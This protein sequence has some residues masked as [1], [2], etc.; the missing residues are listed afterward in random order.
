[1]YL[2]MFFR[3]DPLIV[4]CASISKRFRDLILSAL[5][6]E[7]T[8][9]TKSITR[10]PRAIGTSAKSPNPARARAT[11]N[12]VRRLTVTPTWINEACL[13]KRF[14]RHGEPLNAKVLESGG[15]PRASTA[16]SSPGNVRNMAHRMEGRVPF[17]LGLVGS[18]AVGGCSD[19]S[20][21][22]KLGESREK[23]QV[24]VP[25]TEPNPTVAQATPIVGRNV[26]F[27]GHLFPLS[28]VNVSSFTA[29]AG[30]RVYVAPQ[31]ASS[32]NINHDTL[33]TVLGSDGT[34][35]IEQDDTN[36]FFGS[37]SSIAGALLPAAGTYFVRVA[38]GVNSGQVLPY[39]LHFQLRSGVPLAEVEPNDQIPQSF[40]AG[41]ESGWVSGS[42]TSGTDV[43]LYAISL[44]AGDTLFAS[45]D[46]DPER[47][48]VEWDGSLAFGPLANALQL[49]TDAGDTGP[50]SE[51]M[52]LTVKTA[53]RY[54]VRVAAPNT[55]G[56]FGTYTLSVS[57]HPAE[58]VCTTVMSSTPVTLADAA[59]TTATVNFPADVRIADLDVHLDIAHPNPQ[60]LDVHLIA[61]GG[62]D[63]GLFTD[64][65]TTASPTMNVSLDDEAGFPVGLL[66]IISGMVSQPEQ[67]YRLEWF[68]G[69]RAQGTWT[70][71]IEDDLTTNT[72]TLNAWGLSICSV[73]PPPSCP[74]GT[75]QRVV[76][77]TDFESGAAGF[78][79]SGTADEWELGL[80]TAEPITTCNSGVSCF[81]TDLDGAYENSSN[82]TLVSP[83]VSL[84]GVLAPITLRWAQKYHL[85]SAIFDHASVDVRN[86]DDSSPTRLFEHLG[87]S[88]RET[89]G[90][91]SATV[92]QSAGWSV[93]TAN[94]N[95]YA[96]N[97][98]EVAFHL[99][100]DAAVVYGGMAVN[101][102]SI[103]GCAVVCGDS[104][105][106]AGE[107]CD[108]GNTS[109]GDCCSSMCQYEAVGTTCADADLCDGAETC[110]ATGTCV[111]G[112]P[113]TCTASDACHV[114]EC[115]PA[116]GCANPQAPNGT[117][118]GSGGMCVGGTCMPGAG[119][120]GGAGGSAGA[121]GVA[122]GGAAGRAG[123]GGNAGGMSGA[124]GAAGR[125]G[126]G[127]NAGGMSGASGA[128]GRAGAGGNVGGM[129]GAS[130]AAG[131]SGS[132]GESG[133]GAGGDAGAGAGGEAG[134]GS[135]GGSST[136]GSSTGGSSTGGSSTG[137]SSAEG[138]AGG[139]DEP[140][141]AGGNDEPGGAGGADDGPSND[142]DG[143][144]CTVPGKTQKNG[145][146]LALA[147]ALVAFATRRRRAQPI[148][149]EITEVAA[150]RAADS[151][152]IRE[153]SA[154]FQDS[155]AECPRGTRR[156]PVA[157]GAHRAG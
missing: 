150:S 83:A 90:A 34:T 24:F 18:L 129:S 19:E 139:N 148:A 63:V 88:M 21:S 146:P 54:A 100:S 32:P 6:V 137:G 46:L 53:G 16:G 79:H 77:S 38:P 145:L 130:G 133:A 22:A 103:T 113:V 80:P 4:Q 108:D 74:A 49:I 17:A 104:Q 78:T 112:T 114:A 11:R 10:D 68:D 60:D 147:A 105:V 69:Q 120:A 45:L 91:A 102:V 72:G 3:E 97:S 65:G 157:P 31:S 121:G 123:A 30:D 48:G 126:A 110:N 156:P 136:G 149:Q 42:T 33:I 70:L 51:A 96:G 23:A 61:P 13:G 52:F 127:G 94:I 36:G 106:G 98:V 151:A 7:I 92:L 15:S 58:P 2:A 118:C 142:D 119:G 109:N 29:A 56:T 140:G 47:D 37:S 153:R 86:E 40:Q 59:Q 73:A 71:R 41:A 95:A 64:I 81:K 101:D 125:A 154:R 50:D 132:A 55:M 128:A 152:R 44:A 66:S 20:G 14:E 75:S 8:F 115:V 57:V 116:T 93:R 76:F 62:N 82:Q 28:D 144:G 85:E 5:S 84:S 99:D 27:K 107:Q 141:G 122:G 111:A 9:P 135:T 25:E 87:G 89:I 26:V 117:P 43:D 155:T 131:A 12:L 1:M 138:G 124:G 67:N 143:C 35:V 134:D 39:H